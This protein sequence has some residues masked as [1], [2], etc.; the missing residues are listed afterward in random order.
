MDS[1][2]PPYAL[3]LKGDV[4]KNWQ[5]F[6]Q[7]FQLFL[8]ATETALA[9]RPEATKTALLL[10]LLM[11]IPV[12]LCFEPKD[13]FFCEVSGYNIHDEPVSIMSLVLTPFALTGTVSSW[14]Y[15]IVHTGR[16]GW[17]PN[18]GRSGFLNQNLTHPVGRG[19][20]APAPRLY[21][22]WHWRATWPR[23]WQYWHRGRPS[24][25]RDVFAGHATGGRRTCTS[26]AFMRSVRASVFPPSL[27]GTA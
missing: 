11:K 13:S 15:Y 22:W 4:G 14:F 25:P 16:P 21:R 9:P 2:R 8:T 6:E 7:K 27:P 17:P 1:L 26:V 18:P 20:L 12:G 10:I 24:S 3:R 19:V 5:L 23:R